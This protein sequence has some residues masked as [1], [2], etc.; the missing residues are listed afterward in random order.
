MLCEEA[1]ELGIDVPQSHT[2]NLGRKISSMFEEL[3]FISYQQHKVL[4]YPCTSE[5][6][7]IIIDNFELSSELKSTSSKADS[8][9][10][11]IQ[12]AKLLNAQ[13]K[14]YQTQKSWPSKEEDLKADKI[15]LYSP[16]LLD[17][18][19]TVLISGQSL[20]NEKAKQ[21]KKNLRLKDSFAQDI[22]SLLQME[23]SRHPYKRKYEQ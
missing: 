10:S 3:Q 2:K 13:I 7:T 9:E 23:L 19:L 20:E 22:F 1:N 15:S 17:K 21:K 5:M 16:D 11:V 6:R 12:L 8:E 18:F 14:N 4:V